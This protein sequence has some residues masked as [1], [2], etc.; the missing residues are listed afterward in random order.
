MPAS[1]QVAAC[2]QQLDERVGDEFLVAW[3]HQMPGQPIGE[4]ELVVDLP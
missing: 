3:V 2:P 1:D 4:A